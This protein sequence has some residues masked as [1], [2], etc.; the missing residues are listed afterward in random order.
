M[1]DRK[2]SVFRWRTLIA[3][4]LQCSQIWEREI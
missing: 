4:A 2:Q 1:I 3:K